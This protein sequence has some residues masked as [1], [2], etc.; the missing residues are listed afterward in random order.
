MQDLHQDR[1]A[2]VVEHPLGQAGNQRGTRVPAHHRDPAGIRVQVGAVVDDV[3]E[4]RF[5]IVERRGTW[6]FGRKPVVDRHH[7]A[8][9]VTGQLHAMRVIGVQVPGHE[10]TAV[11]IHHHRRP[12]ISRAS[13]Q[14]YIQA[15]AIGT[16]DGSRFDADAAGVDRRG[17][18][19]GH[20]IRVL[21]LG[22]QRLVAEFDG[23]PARPRRLAARGRYGS[24]LA[25]V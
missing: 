17:T 21:A 11:R 16:G 12:E 10:A 22:G 4:T 14:T 24:G 13:V 5:E 9:G 20:Q 15:A 7:Q 6:M 18:L 3:A 23:R 25:A 8:A 2:F 19:C 1:R